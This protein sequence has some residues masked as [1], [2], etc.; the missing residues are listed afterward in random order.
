MNAARLP[1]LILGLP[2]MGVPASFYARF[3]D[4]LGAA[5][6]ADVEFADLP[7]QGARPERARDGAD[8]GYREIVEQELPDWVARRRAEQPGRPILLLGHSL[9]GQLALLASATLAARI[10]GLVLVAA[11]TA[12]WRV[13]PAGQRRRAWATVQV[14]R[15]LSALWPWYPGQLLGFGGNQPRRLMRDWSHNATTGRYQLEGGSRDVAAI[16]RALHAVTLPVLLLGLRDDPIAPDGARDELIARLPCARVTRALIDGV[17]SDGPWR[18]HFSWARA[19][20]EAVQ[21]VAAWLAALPAQ[22]EAA[23]TGSGRACHARPALHSPMQ[24]A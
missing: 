7:G 3:A 14:V 11:G 1:P 8:F 2:A 10:D 13:W 17:R 19:P 20:A 4:A 6:G 15:A 22:R 12:H 24:L 9:G 16:E 23:E 18:R 21:A 5:T